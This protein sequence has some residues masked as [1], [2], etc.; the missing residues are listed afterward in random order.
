MSEVTTQTN[1]KELVL[2]R[3]LDAPRELVFKAWTEAERLAHWWGPVG[4]ELGISKMDLRPGGTFLYSM[5]TPEGMEMWGKFTF[6]EIE[7]PE[8]LV[9][10]NSF[11]D[12]DG[13]VTRAPFSA[14]WPLE[15]YNILTLTEQDGKTRL[16]LRGY[17]INATE[18]ELATFEGMRGSMN[19]GWAGTFGQLDTYLA[20]AQS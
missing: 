14:T 9:F 4:F 6:H 15:V 11:S 5:K 20:G 7:A 13:S 2:E 3:V 17:P 18:E 10:V 19:E 8:K 1:D 12:P 16:V